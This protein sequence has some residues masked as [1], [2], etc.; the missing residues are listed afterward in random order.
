MLRAIYHVCKRCCMPFVVIILVGITTHSFCFTAGPRPREQLPLPVALE[1][2]RY[3]SPDNGIFVASDPRRHA[4]DAA[5]LRIWSLRTGM[6]L[7][8]LEGFCQGDISIVESHDGRSLYAC[9]RIFVP[10]A[11]L[12]GL[13]IGSLRQLEKVT[14]WD[15]ASGKIL[16]SFRVEHDI[17][18]W[19]ELFTSPN[20][21]H[22]FIR[23]YDK[24]CEWEI[25]SG[26]LV[27][28]DPERVS[29]PVD[30][31][32]QYFFDR[33]TSRLGFVVDAKSRYE[34]RDPEKC[35]LER[36]IS[37][38]EQSVSFDRP[39][40]VTSD[41]KAL[42]TT[43][44]D[45][46]VRVWS[47]DTGALLECYS[48]PCR[49]SSLRTSSS[50]RYVI[51]DEKDDGP[52]SKLV[53]PYSPKIAHTL[54]RVIPSD[55]E[56][57][58]IDRHTNSVHLGFPSLRN[59]NDRIA[60]KFLDH[61][62]FVRCSLYGFLDNEQAFAM[63]TPD[64]ILQWDLPPKWQSFTPSAWLW[65]TVAAGLSLTQAWFTCTAPRL[66]FHRRHLSRA[67]N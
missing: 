34:I 6:E 13:P 67:R 10:A 55:A 28:A 3:V 17:P 49:P 9:G 1:N 41:G 15:L 48:A 54:Q 23:S 30:N 25:K 5:A 21:E 33:E 35:T 7:T 50:G 4:T 65:L 56:M 12:N 38:P 29:L 45:G 62:T 43:D 66:A 58:L 57:I 24:L 47:I 37:W 63:L 27:E 32:T 60:S 64:G 26:G 44:G 52:L 40:S 22:L 36:T 53:R 2:V 18:Y 16:R 19:G 8:V 51:V 42:I 61:S 11:D 31:R 39:F 46:T 20:D 59:T 14:Q